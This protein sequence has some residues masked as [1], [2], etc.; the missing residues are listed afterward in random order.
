MWQSNYFNNALKDGRQVSVNDRCGDGSASDFT[1]IEY[2]AVTD[3]PTRYDTMKDTF[4]FFCVQGL[5]PYFRFW[6][7]TRGMDPFSF[8]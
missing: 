1:T 2:K 3:I 5:K 8:G 4:I 7:A 6:E